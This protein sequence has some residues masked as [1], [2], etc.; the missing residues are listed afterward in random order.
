MLWPR[1]I[2]AQ[3]IRCLENGKLTKEEC[4]KATTATIIKEGYNL[5][6]TQNMLRVY[7]GYRKRRQV[8]FEGRKL[9]AG[10]KGIAS[11]RKA[12]NL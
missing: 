12:I 2:F 11:A 5:E 6:G 9:R 8:L 3:Y 1:Q 10:E 4:A 7:M